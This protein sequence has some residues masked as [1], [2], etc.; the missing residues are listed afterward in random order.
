MRKV[1]LTGLLLIG[2]ASSVSGESSNGAMRLPL[3]VLA[4]TGTIDVI[5]TFSGG[6]N[7]ENNPAI[8]WM[9]PTVGFKGTVTIGAAIEVAAVLVAC[10]LLCRR[11]PKLAR[12]L[13]YIGAGIHGAAAVDNWRRHGSN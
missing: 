4:T 12:T 1:L 7:Y 2:T 9:Q 6:A 10:K 11:K 8:R 13:I 3:S 5:S